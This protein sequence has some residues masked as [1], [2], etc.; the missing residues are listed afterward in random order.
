[1]PRAV[2]VDREKSPTSAASGKLVAPAATICQPVA[3]KTSIPDFQRLASTDPSAHEKDPPSKLAEDHNSLRPRFEV[4][5]NCGQNRTNK[6]AMP[7]A[8]PALPR[9]EM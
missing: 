9:P 3:V 8:S 4:A 2:Q 6:P 1:M 7:S 5:C